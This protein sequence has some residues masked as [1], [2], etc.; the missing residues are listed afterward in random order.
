[1]N[2]NKFGNRRRKVEKK[3]GNKKPVCIA[4]AIDAGDVHMDGVIATDGTVIID[5]LDEDDI[6]NS[7]LPDDDS[8]FH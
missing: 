8:S 1:M 2:G 5:T 7:Y 6:E 3:K 4:A